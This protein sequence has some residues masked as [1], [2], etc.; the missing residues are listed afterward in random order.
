MEEVCKRGKCVEATQ[1]AEGGDLQSRPLKCRAAKK[2][3][4]LVLALTKPL[5][6]GGSGH[7][8]NKQA[9][10]SQPGQNLPAD[11]FCG[12]LSSFGALRRFAWRHSTLTNFM[13]TTEPLLLPTCCWLRH[14]RG[15]G[16]L[17]KAPCSFHSGDI[18]AFM[19]PVWPCV[20]NKSL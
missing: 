7:A 8:E 12:S 11:C 2:S 1:A 6:H 9:G 13:N 18:A 14:L 15:W 10:P 17:Q 4:G 19:P 5:S 20:S 16:S 3:A